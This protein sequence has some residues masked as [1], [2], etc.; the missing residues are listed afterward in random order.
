MRC[1]LLSKLTVS[2]FTMDSP[3]IDYH[4]D[5]TLGALQ[6]TAMVSSALYGITV[7]Q[8][9]VYLH[10]INHDS[11]LTKAAVCLLWTLNTLHQ[12][13]ICHAVYLFTITDYGNIVDLTQQTWSIVAVAFVSACMDTGVRSMFCVRIWR[14][15][16]RKWLLIAIIML[17]SLGE[18]AAL[19]ALGIKDVVTIHFD[20]S[21]L[22]SLSPE[23]YSATVFTI[24]A[25]SIIAASQVVL[26][27][28]YRSKV[29]RTKS[30]V[31]SLTI[32]SINT[33]LLTT[34]CALLMLITWSS[35]PNNLVYTIFYNALPSLLFNALL[36]TFN[37]RQELREIGYG[38]PDMIT[39]PLSVVAQTSSFTVTHAEPSQDARESAGS[40]RIK[41]DQVHDIV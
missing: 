22:H 25:D 21:G 8:T 18:F 35:M 32:Y 20:F 41:K 13:F 34:F 36:A 29:P 39:V 16:G 11:A 17:S 10:Q 12:V 31:R 27:W 38:N 30:I 6:I 28:N 24:I 15:S 40:D 26:L 33:G 23:F 19:F 3:P 4:L 5:S 7:I 37:A 2:L 14:L 1:A 9:Y